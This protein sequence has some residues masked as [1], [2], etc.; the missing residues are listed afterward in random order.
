MER[1]IITIKPFSIDGYIIKS[2]DVIG[3][4]TTDRRY[5]INREIKDTLEQ[6]HHEKKGTI[7]VDELYRIKPTLSIDEKSYSL[8]EIFSI[9][10]KL[11]GL[12]VNSQ[13]K[14]YKKYSISPEIMKETI[15]NFSYQIKD[16]I[17]N[18]KEIQQLKEEIEQKNQ[19]IKI[20]DLKIAAL[21]EVINEMKT[22]NNDP[23]ILFDVEK[24]K[25]A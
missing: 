11:N 6:F 2:N 20:Q 21:T 23:D 9:M 17:L 12:A 18:N 19:K 22:K 13:D 5:R 7:E 15:S 25:I 1:T 4:P 3:F 24:S 16:D 10:G 14:M 8:K